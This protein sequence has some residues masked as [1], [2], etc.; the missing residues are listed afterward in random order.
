MNQ[1]LYHHRNF[2]QMHRNQLFWLFEMYDDYCEIQELYE[3]NS[4]EKSISFDPSV[5]KTTRILEAWCLS[6]IKL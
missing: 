3:L 4:Q 6:S 1:E 2:H 5:S